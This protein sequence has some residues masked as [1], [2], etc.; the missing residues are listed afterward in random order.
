MGFIRGAL[1]TFF[2]IVFFLSLIFMNF[3]AVLSSS[4]EYDNLQPALK[5]SA[6]KI[7]SNFLEEGSMFSGEERVYL[8]NYCSIE[9]EYIFTYENYTFPI[10]CEIMEQGESSIVEY[11]TDNFIEVIYYAE[12]NC[13]FWECVKQSSI[14]FVLISQKARDYWYHNFLILFGFSIILFALTFFISGN[15]PWRFI[16]GGILIIFSALPFRNLNWILRFVPDNLDAIFSVFFTKAHSVFIVMIVIGILFIAG[17]ILCKIFGW[18][19][20]FNKKEE[21]NIQKKKSSK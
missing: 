19:L 1:V 3:T 15:R 12:Y 9:S 16:I 20:K 8:E 10:P 11:V 14:P 13:E 7:L 17:G 4:L 18:D 21:Q 2:S 6:D 5:S